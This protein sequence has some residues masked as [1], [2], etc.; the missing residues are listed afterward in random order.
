VLRYDDF[1][2]EDTVRMCGPKALFPSTELT[3]GIA[4][5]GDGDQQE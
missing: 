2:L 1:F 3:T 5:N 4:A